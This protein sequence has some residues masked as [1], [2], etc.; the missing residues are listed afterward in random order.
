MAKIKGLITSKTE[1][2][3]KEVITYKAEEV[4]TQVI[5]WGK[6]P[7]GTYFKGKLNGDYIDGQILKDTWIYLCG[8]QEILEE[9][10]D[11]EF[12]YEHLYDIDYGTPED[13]ENHCITDLEFFDSKPRGFKSIIIPLLDLEYDENTVRIKKGHIEVGCQEMCND[14]VRKIVVALVD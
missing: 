9:C 14:D 11:E 3:Q 13:L 5:D 7:H 4:T 8:S 12:G 1:T 6:I 2:I 10:D